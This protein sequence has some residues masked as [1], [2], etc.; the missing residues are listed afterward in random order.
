[1]PDMETQTDAGTDTGGDTTNAG[2]GADTGT[3]TPPAIIDA[4]GNFGE[5]WRNVLDEDI[6]NDQSITTFRDLKSLAKSYVHARKMIGSD[7][8]KVP[9]ENA[10]DEEWG[11]IH[12]K[13]GR[14]ESADGYK[15]EVPQELAGQFDEE[16]IKQGREL[17]HAI[18]L[19]Q[20]QVDKLWEFEQQRYVSALQS[21]QQQ[22]EASAEEA[23]KQLKKDWGDDYNGNI[24]L[25]NVAINQGAGGNE[26]LKARIIEK[27][28]SDPDFVRF[29]FR[30]GSMFSEHRIITGDTKSSEAIG[31]VERKINEILKDETYLKGT[32]MQR[33]PLVE[34]LT[35]LYKQKA[36]LKPKG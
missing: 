9:G 14:P 12:R 36:E 5:G 21:Q 15:L 1:M 31:D 2:A 32:T 17:F 4:E 18:G 20:K 30:L 27:F 13:L 7:Q 28:G 22:Q 25:G 33:R 29:A 35:Q 10:T 11:E 8:V 3:A 24:H 26:E 19:N 34:R 16:M 23:E 6:R